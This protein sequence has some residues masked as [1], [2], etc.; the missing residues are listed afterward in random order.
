LP[1]EAPDGAFATPT[2]PSLST[3]VALTVGV[4]RESSTSAAKTF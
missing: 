2:E 1:V 4:P 3:T